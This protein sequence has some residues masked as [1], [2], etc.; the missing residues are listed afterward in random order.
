MRFVRI[1]DGDLVIVSPACR[2]PAA[3]C[4]PRA[5]LAAIRR[6]ICNGEYDHPDVLRETARRMLARGDI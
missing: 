1:V 4:R 6:R 2:T 3:A 5:E